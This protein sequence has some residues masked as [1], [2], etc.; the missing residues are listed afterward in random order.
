MTAIDS[1]IDWKTLRIHKPSEVDAHNNIHAF[2]K[3][4]EEVH[5]L[6]VKEIF[7]LEDEDDER[8]YLMFALDLEKGELQRRIMVEMPAVPLEY[9]RYLGLRGEDP[10]HFIRMDVDHSNWL[11]KFAVGV[12]DISTDP[13]D[14]QFYETRCPE[15]VRIENRVHRCFRNSLH[16]G[17]CEAKVVLA[18]YDQRELGP[19][20]WTY[21][22][23][24]SARRIL[25]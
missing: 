10:T 20:I 15:E 22:K 19:N 16:R 13:D 9:V 17:K 8:G 2:V 14:A 24:K 3:D 18:G 6:V 5:G 1:I 4:I 25:T 23:W 21:I 11:W 7:R 12:A